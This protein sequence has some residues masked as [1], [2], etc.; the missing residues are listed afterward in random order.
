L[1]LLKTRWAEDSEL[2]AL[3][4]LLSSSKLA[5]DVARML[6]LDHEPSKVSWVLR[7]YSP[8]FL[9]VAWVAEFRFLGVVAV[10]VAKHNPAQ[11]YPSLVVHLRGSHAVAVVV[12]DEVPDGARIRRNPVRAQVWI[13]A[14]QVS[15]LA[16]LDGDRNATLR[17]MPRAAVREVERE[18]VV[19]EAVLEVEE[20]LLLVASEQCR[21]V[22]LPDAKVRRGEEKTCDWFLAW[23]AGGT[24]RKGKT[25][26]IYVFVS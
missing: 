20:H 26:H 14:Q 21:S 9:A 5:G 25:Q 3:F 6:V 17:T 16:E 1:P 12:P 13:Q 24:E 19:A 4:Q 23:E 7:V 15:S 11:V 18:L 8:V 10:A 2:V 22:C